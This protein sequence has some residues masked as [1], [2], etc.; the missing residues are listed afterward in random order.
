MILLLTFYYLIQS[1][2]LA[3]GE[4]E[5]RKDFWHQGNKDKQT[6]NFDPEIEKTL[7]KHRKQSKLQKQ[8]QEGSSEEVFEEVLVN[9]AD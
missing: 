4:S 6:L 1:G 3:G 7:R 5:F 2:A 9:M 8:T